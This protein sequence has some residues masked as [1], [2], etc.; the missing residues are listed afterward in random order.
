LLSCHELV[1]AFNLRSP[2]DNASAV[3]TSAGFVPTRTNGYVI[4]S[5]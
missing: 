1:A 2:C 4:Q 5:N 3:T